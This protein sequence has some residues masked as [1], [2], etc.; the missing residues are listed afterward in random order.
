MLPRSAKAD[1]VHPDCPVEVVR[2]VDVMLA[3]SLVRQ[4]IVPKERLGD[5]VERLCP[6]IADIP[7]AHGFELRFDMPE[8]TH[9]ALLRGRI[10]YQIRR[11]PTN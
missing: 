2:A 6:Q 10:H 4:P 7:A 5:V 9:A 3:T 8:N 11:K 1:R